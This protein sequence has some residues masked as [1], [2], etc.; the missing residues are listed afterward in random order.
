MIEYE[1]NGGVLFVIFALLM[2]Y[3]TLAIIMKKA[4]GITINE[5]ILELFCLCIHL[6]F[7]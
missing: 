4:T 3:S 6:N 1:T 2:F 5:Y 7:V